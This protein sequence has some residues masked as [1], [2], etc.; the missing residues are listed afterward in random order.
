MPWLPFLPAVFN[1]GLAFEHKSLKANYI[2]VLPATHSGGYVKIFA[3]IAWNCS[4]WQRCQQ[5]KPV[6]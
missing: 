1:L 5:L 4:D 2:F 6:E 3:T